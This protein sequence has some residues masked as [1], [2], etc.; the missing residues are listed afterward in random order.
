MEA[1]QAFAD[2][3]KPGLPH[4][5]R[6]PLIKDQGQ[7]EAVLL[8]RLPDRNQL[9]PLHIVI[10]SSRL[11]QTCHLLSGHRLHQG[12]HGFKQLL[13]IDQ[14]QRIVHPH[15][16]TLG[17][18]HTRLGQEL[19]L[20]PWRCPLRLLRSRQRWAGGSGGPGRGI[21][22]FLPLGGCGLGWLSLFGLI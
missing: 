6:K 3:L 12:Q 16:Q 11:I 9:A 17:A 19:G 21:V 14:I 1:A 4:S 22:G 13:G 7:R 20:Q 10:Q 18:R 15:R 2:V 5:H 8:I